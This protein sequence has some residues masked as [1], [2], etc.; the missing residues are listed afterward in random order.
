M[1]KRLQ[2]RI[3][4][5]KLA[6]P[7]TAVYAVGV[8]LICGLITKEWW[9]QFG[10]FA[11]AAYLMVEL[12]N[13]NALIRIYSRIVS[14]SF[15]ALTCSACFL[16]PSIQG[17]IVQTTIIGV[18]LLLFLTYQKPQTV[19]I[20][21]YAFLLWSI[22][23]M[24]SIHLVFYLPL[25]WLFMATHLQSLSWRTC[26]ASILGLLTPYWVGSCWL[27]W[28]GDFTPLISHF[29]QLADFQI[30][31]QFSMLSVGQI[32]VYAFLLLL[33]IIGTVHF[34]RQQHNDKIR[35]RQ[36]YGFFIWMNLA[37]ALM[38]ALQ[39]QHYDFLIRMMFVC[40]APVIGHFLA[41]THTKLTNIAFFLLVII[42]LVITGYN[43]WM[44]SY[45]F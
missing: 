18:F 10:L 14:C 42:T 28:E 20:V 5:S 8:W 39:P 16:F 7:V 37:T 25:L 2:N 15:L 9:V 11:I 43:L 19:G 45:L 32:A 4:E 38:L 21:Y 44:S 23:T 31:L 30:P 41:L 29:E 34:I 12:N 36:L 26:G 3:A 13:I 24:V 27:V 40:T 17:A 33:T 1:I 35:I 6:L 22:G